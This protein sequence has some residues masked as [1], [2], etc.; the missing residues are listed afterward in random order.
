MKGPDTKRKG[1][2]HYD[3][4]RSRED[5]R[6]RYQTGFIGLLFKVLQEKDESP[7]CDYL[8]SNA[9][10]SDQDREGLA[11]LI[12]K[13]LLRGGRPYGRT[14]GPVWDAEYWIVRQ[15]KRFKEKWREE[16]G[17]PRVPKAATGTE[18]DRLIALAEKR[19]PNAKGK[20][21]ADH[22]RTLLTH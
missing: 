11:W 12:E 14:R 20:I 8:R 1:A 9:P 7:L 18:I 6:R 16:R 4:E 21:N 17:R 13:L 2:F 3:V 19:F 10:L 15:V 5:Y 22:I